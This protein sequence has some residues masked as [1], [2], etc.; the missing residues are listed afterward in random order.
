M[1]KSTP[2]YYISPVSGR[3]IKSNAKTYD[4]LKRRR[5]NIDKEPCLYNVRSA[6]KCLNK[7]LRLYP[8]I[9][10]PSSNF[11]DI[12][13]TY[14]HGNVRAFIKDKK[15]VIGYVDKF[16]NKHR[17]YKP[18]HTKRPIPVVHDSFNVLADILEKQDKISEKDQKTIEKQIIKGEPLTESKNI[19]ILFNPIQNDFIPIK[20]KLADD[21]KREIINTINKE[22]IPTQL[23]PITM[24]SNI[25][26]II[27]EYDTIV[28][29][30]NKDNVI[31]KFPE[32][33]K[34]IDEHPIPGPPGP[35][36]ERGE[37]GE[38]GETGP[39]GP[40][41]ERGEVGPQGPQGERGE[42]GPQ[43]PQ[44]ERGETG[45]QGERGEASQKG[46][47]GETG[48]QGPQGP[49]GERGETGPQ[50]PQGER[51]EAGPQGPQ[52]E[53]GETGFQGPQGERGETATSEPSIPDS[54]TLPE[55]EKEESTVSEPTE[56]KEESTV[57]EPSE[58]IKTEEST[59]S[60]PTEEKEESTVS[61]PTEEKEESTVS[62]PTEE[63]E[64]STVSEPTEEIKT[65][66]S[67]VS[68]PTEEI[69]TEESTVSEPT[70]EKE[71]STVSEPT[72]EIKTEESIVSEPIEEKEE[73]TVSEPTEEKEE[74]IENVISKSIVDTLPSITVIKQDDS[75]VLD[76]VLELSP[77]ISKQETDE[78]I[79]GLQCLDGEQ[80]DPNENRCLPCTHYGLVW[81]PE[82]KV[83][84]TMLKEEILKEQDKNLLSDGF[85]LNKLDIM[86]DEKGNVVGYLEK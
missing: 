74:Q 42:V 47:R 11:I 48:L 19:N 63:K 37:R 86:S 36:G 34:I 83:C 71:E 31:Q 32:P 29:I 59:V 76:K 78:I 46:E 45:P 40:Q 72:E 35:Q 7:L 28:G 70:E 8:D 4:D 41:G 43:G 62:E 75:S 6:H 79:K 1:T 24:F 38:R 82:H 68:E 55:T 81:D 17:L 27:K 16:G 22:L 12:P 54:L 13:K 67:T 58:E 14:K 57:S 60:E 49:Q 77:V 10:H 2:K 15:R 26:G 56:E 85:I 52:G 25:S 61:E 84:K 64:E 53:R 33:I 5:F 39:Q 65:E 3:L 51:G 69:K 50:G 21:E 44:G 73:S 18:I 23:P 80:L 30:I 20:T 66:E 9:V